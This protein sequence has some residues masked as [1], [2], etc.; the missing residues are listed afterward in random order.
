MI[1]THTIYGRPTA[2]S[3]AG[4]FSSLKNAVK[5]LADGWR[6]YTAFTALNDLDDAALAARGLT[7][8]DL[9]RVAL[10]EMLR[11]G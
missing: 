2:H 8:A 5:G 10:D 4:V 7:R 6:G 9:P 11:R 3:G 1:S